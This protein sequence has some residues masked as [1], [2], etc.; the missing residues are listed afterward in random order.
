MIQPQPNWN[1]GHGGF[2][3]PGNMPPHIH[4]P[5]AIGQ[6]D[7]NPLGGEPTRWLGGLFG[8]Q[9]G[10][11]LIGPNHPGFGTGRQPGGPNIRFDPP[12]PYEG[13]P[14][15]PYGGGPNFG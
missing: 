13:W 4:D 6:N 12:G 2:S 3:H 1:P 9:R 15:G 11:N 7:I 10:G 14:P 5:F 8:N